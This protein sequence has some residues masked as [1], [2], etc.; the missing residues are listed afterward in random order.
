VIYVPESKKIGSLLKEF[1][2]KHQQLAIIVDEYGNTKG[3][4][5]MEDILEELVG[6]IQDE[7]DEE[8]PIVKKEDNDLFIVLAAAPIRDINKYLPFP[9]E[10]PDQN[11]TLSGYIIAQLGRMPGMEETLSFGKYEVTIIKRSRNIISLVQLRL[12]SF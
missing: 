11:E 3:I 4:V 9:I 2:A 7:Y 5:T 10:P 1:Q 12:S 8:Y 6:E